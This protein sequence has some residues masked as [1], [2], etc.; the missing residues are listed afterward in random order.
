[1]KRKRIFLDLFSEMKSSNYNSSKLMFSIVNLALFF[2]G[3]LM[4]IIDLFTSQYVSL[5]VG[6]TFSILSF[7]NYIL[8]RC[9]NF[10]QSIVNLLFTIETIAI[11]LFFI[12]YGMSNGFSI[13]WILLI[14]LFSCFVFGQKNGSLYS[15]MVLFLLILLFWTPLG[16]ILLQ[17]EYTN[18]F[19]LRFPIL[20]ISIYALSIFTGFVLQKTNRRLSILEEKYYHL[21]RHDEL[22]SLYNRYGFNERLNK[23][24][25][26]LSNQSVSMLIVDLDDFKNVND[27]FGHSHG[28][29]V[30]Q[31][32]A[33][34]IKRNISS[35]CIY[36][37]WGGEEFTIF[38][39]CQDDP[40]EIASKISKDIVN[41]SFNKSQN[42]I[43]LTVS[44]GIC[45]ANNISN[46]SAEEMFIQADKCLYESKNNGKNIIT[47]TT[48]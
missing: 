34:I 2:I 31:E 28:D 38:I 5:F 29:V 43:N 41:M 48:I 25:E 9:Q 1:M 4:A 45:I 3:L 40:M 36:C 24:F 14:P 7:I 32:V 13:L 10:K 30:L 22:T 12:I 27:I 35:Q 39:A 8:S 19:K 47:K 18:E 23:Y 44:I 15:F 6:L 46:V 11:V 42:I 20:Y 21:Y 17:Y 37:R 16:N 26:E 33:K